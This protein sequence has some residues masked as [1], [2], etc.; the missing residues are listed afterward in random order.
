[1]NPE[2]EIVNLWLSKK[3]FFTIN[4]INAGK[5]KIIG[6]IAVKLS[7]GKLEKVQHVEVSCSV[8]PG[9]AE[10][11]I[12]DYIRKFYDKS[13]TATIRQKAKKFGLFD[14]YEKVLV[15]SS[16]KK[17]S[18]EGIEIINFRDIL[19]EVTSGIDRQNYRSPA[20]RTIQL[21]KYLLISDPERI[22]DIIFKSEGNKPMTG[23]SREL[24]LKSALSHEQA[25]KIFEKQSNEK[26]L[27]QLLKS[28]TLKKPERLASVLENEILTGRTRKKFLK[29][30][31][32]QEKISK[33]GANL[34]ITKGQK[35]LKQYLR[36]K[37]TSG[38][39]SKA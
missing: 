30:L 38:E 29:S 26:L 1:M 36:K 39:Q 16:D 9:I 5:N 27:V 23:A 17:I 22:S 3:G 24:F 8:S 15:I 10:K 4:D 6:L 33:A 11:E 18:S 2:K 32:S 34:I 25:K 28:S 31:L 37:K 19:L 21:L 35:S 14:T 12:E 7:N 20:L 13:V